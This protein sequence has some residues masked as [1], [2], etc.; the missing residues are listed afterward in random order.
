MQQWL[1]DWWL[2][3]CCLDA[4]VR[5]ADRPVVIRVADHVGNTLWSLNRS[6]GQLPL[7]TYRRHNYDSCALSC[8]TAVTKYPF[9]GFSF[10][11]KEY[12]RCSACHRRETANTSIM[13]LAGS[14]GGYNSNEVRSGLG[15]ARNLHCTL[16][17]NFVVVDV[18]RAMSPVCYTIVRHDAMSLSLCFVP[19]LWRQ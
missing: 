6:I 1:L 5:A 4:H 15:K 19:L 2:C 7:V 16:W 3:L 14:K 18:F 10:G 11:D 8:R 9:V 12:G 17:L 13:Y